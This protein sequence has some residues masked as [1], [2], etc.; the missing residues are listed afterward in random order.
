M[1]SFVDYVYITGR[2]LSLAKAS[3]HKE[4]ILIDCLNSF[5]LNTSKIFVSNEIVSALIIFT[6]SELLAYH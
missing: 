1:R 2:K 4:V 6:S 5:N 3:R